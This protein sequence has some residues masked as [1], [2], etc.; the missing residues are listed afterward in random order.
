MRGLQAQHAPPFLIDQHRRVR[1]SY[2]L[3]Q[4]ADESPDLL[5]FYAV[6]L[7]QNEAKRIDGPEE[8]PLRL[9]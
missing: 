9:R 1:S 6:P 3:A 2:R 7:E 5:R 4:V 8:P